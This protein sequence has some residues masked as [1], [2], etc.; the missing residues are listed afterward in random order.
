[1][2]GRFGEL[3]ANL[4]GVFLKALLDFFLEDFFQSSI[5]KTFVSLRREI[6]NQV[7]DQRAREPARLGIRVVRQERI[8]RWTTAG[9]RRSAG[10]RRSSWCGSR[11]RRCG[12]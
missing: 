1:M 3:F 9:S 4:V 11:R 5:A 12:W 7:G 10:A 2:V 6:R 8:D